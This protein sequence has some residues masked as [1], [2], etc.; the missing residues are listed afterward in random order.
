MG[1]RKHWLSD[2]ILITCL[3]VK[4]NSLTTI[5]NFITLAMFNYKFIEIATHFWIIKPA[6]HPTGTEHRHMMEKQAKFHRHYCLSV[7]GDRR[8]RYIKSWTSFHCRVQVW[9]MWSGCLNAAEF[10]LNTC[11]PMKAQ[12]C[13]SQFEMCQ[14]WP[15][16]GSVLLLLHP[17]PQC[18]QQLWQPAPTAAPRRR[19]I[20]TAWRAPWWRHT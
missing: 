17:P 20:F 13:A 7:P 1:D 3:H 15:A 2:F 19:P 9:K 18:C 6:C 8:K 4:V 5:L 12:K 11:K 14:H 10:I 16:E